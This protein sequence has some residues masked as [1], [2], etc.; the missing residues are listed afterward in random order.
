MRFGA[1][2]CFFSSFRSNP[3]PIGRSVALVLEQRSQF[4]RERMAG[5]S[6]A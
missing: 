3:L 4:E 1:K 2:P 6:E 5:L